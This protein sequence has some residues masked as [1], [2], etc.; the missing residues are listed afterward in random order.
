MK[1][2]FKN[3]DKEEFLAEITD[4]NWEL[5]DEN[6]S[7]SLSKLLDRVET[8]LNKYAPYKKII[9]KEIKNITKPWIM[10]G[11]QKS[12][13]RKDK[14]YKLMINESNV[15]IKHNLEEQYKTL[16]Q[17][18]FNITRSSKKL[19]YKNY[20]EQNANNIKK[21]WSG[22]NEIIQN[23]QKSRDKIN[24]IQNKHGESVSDGKKISNEFNDFFSGIA[25]NLLNKR[26]YGGNK[27]FT[28]YLKTSN[29]KTCFLTP[30]DE[31]EV[32]TIIQK[33]DGNKSQGPYL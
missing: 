14:L 27:H 28:D 4:L 26:R 13:S 3:M 25:G 11:I 2:S 1:R 23:K 10:R 15:T 22:V 32:K 29:R 6:P 16:K 8:R 21:L 9:Q 31:S 17:K 33:L 5:T 24:L 20:F 18:I 19:H 7:D 30:V 12:I